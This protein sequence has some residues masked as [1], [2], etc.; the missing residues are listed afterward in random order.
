MTPASIITAARLKYNATDDTTYFTE[1]ELY[2][3]L[4]QGEVELSLHS[5]CI[6]ITTSTTTVTG[7]SQYTLPTNSF[8]IK[9]IT[10]D[11]VKLRPI[12]FREDDALTLNDADTTDKGTPAYYVIWG[13]IVELRPIPDKA[14]T[15]QFRVYK[16]PEVMTAAASMSTPVRYHMWLTDYIISEM[17]AKEQNKSQA[18]HYRA[19]WE[20]HKSD[21][22]RLER[23]RRRGDGFAVVKDEDQLAVT[24]LGLL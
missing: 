12:D 6:E 23:K 3:Y 2:G 20:Q 22:K 7:T 8:E 11:G 15:L 21:A 24:I 19:L 9:R 17:Y 13:D 1:A 5:R 4:Y 16:N 10:Y 14:K 18:M